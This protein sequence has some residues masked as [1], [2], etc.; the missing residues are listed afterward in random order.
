MRILALKPDHDGSVAY[1][2]D[3][4]LVF[5]L[6]AEK[7]SFPRHSTVSPQLIIQAL[8]M[9]PDFPDVVA[10][11]GWHKDLPD[12][13]SGI[14]TGY[15]GLERIEAREGLFFGKP[16]KMFSSS[17]ERSHIFM[18]TA[19]APW[20]PLKECIVLIWEG[21]IGAFYHYQEY[22][23]KLSRIDVLT[24][25]GARYSALFALGDPRFPDRD[26][27]PRKEDAGKLMALTGYYDGREIP[28]CDQVVVERLL[29]SETFYPFD[30]ASYQETKLYNCGVHTPRM[31][32]AAHY[33]TDRL[34]QIFFDQANRL[35][36]HGLPLV[37]SGGC[38]LNCEWNQRWRTCGLFSEVFVPPCTND[39]GSAIGTAAD[40]MVHFG[41]P[42][43]LDWTVYAGAPFFHD[44]E[45]DA[46]M[47]TQQ[48]VDLGAIALRLVQ[49]EVFAWVQGRY[50]IGPRALGHRS[51]LASPVAAR[52]KDLLNTIKERE[53]YRPIA[54]CCMYEDLSR[55]FEPAIDDPYMLY[56]SRV[57]T[58][59]LP[60]ITHVDGTARV[61]SV[62]TEIEPT[63]HGLLQAFKSVTGYGVLCNTSLNFKGAGF[64]NRTSE[65]A[66]YCEAKGINEFVIDD[67]WYS[68]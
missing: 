45:P 31:H 37:I 62:R 20:A 27:Y 7:D 33:M 2:E 15:F 68:R 43:Q 47:W 61:Q 46:D 30:K 64:I 6:E 34:F 29:E 13:S 26:T 57:L 11:G 63:L 8:E 5:S 53:I 4:R 38:G 67:S 17:H 35:V 28:A 54:P 39:S 49:G 66:A 52:N 48:P 14:A 60:A 56:F 65:L 25:P 3:G 19:M 42:C 59:A 1:V 50:E 23:K 16:V 10:I 12:L 55:W 21:V 9:A 44:V 58:P 24:Q 22:G 18:A 41:E 36:P 51:L 40:A 32:A